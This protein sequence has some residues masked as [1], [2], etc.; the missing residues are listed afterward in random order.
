MDEDGHE[1]GQESGR[2]TPDGVIVTAAFAVVLVRSIEA[3][4]T[5]AL[6]VAGVVR[7]RRTCSAI[8][9]IMSSAVDK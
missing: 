1:Q 9:R 4:I 3:G 7:A 5:V 2:V 8:C 6:R